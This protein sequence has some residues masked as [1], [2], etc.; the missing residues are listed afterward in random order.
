MTG[1]KTNPMQKLQLTYV[2]MGKVFFFLNI[3]KQV[4]NIHSRANIHTSGPVIY[5]SNKVIAE[6]NTSVGLTKQIILAE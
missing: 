4:T 5:S 3:S 1:Y 6:L 2:S